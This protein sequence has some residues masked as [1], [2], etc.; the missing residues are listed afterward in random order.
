MR[1]EAAVSR[2]GRPYP[3]IEVV[4]L[5]EPREG[6][7]LVRIIACGVCHTD[8]SVHEERGPWP[9]IL[10]HEGVGVVE[11]TGPGVAGFAEGDRVLLTAA[12]HCGEC[13]SCRRGAYPY[14]VHADAL[15]FRGLRPDG[16]TGA[17]QDGAP[18]HAHFFG[19]SSFARYALAQARS[20]VRLPGDLPPELLAPLGCGVGTGAGSV[21]F[22]LDLRV[23]QSIAV[24]GTG[25]VGLSAIMAARL[26]GAARIVAVDV[27][28][29]RLALARELGATDTVDTRTADPVAAVRDAT[30]GGADVTFNTTRSPKVYD[31]MLAALAP[32]GT[33]GFVAPAHDPWAPDLTAMMV[34]GQSVRGII[35][36]GVAA[37]VVV[38][39]LIDLHRQGRFPFDRL[40]REYPFE[41]I[42][43]AFADS[44]AGT[45]VKPV[46]R[47]A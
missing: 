34:G 5:E 4:E 33:A 26:A 28:P 11:R 17:S 19:Q 47:M 13:R 42:G 8:L 9:I 44:E 15:N 6:E 37:D 16:T 27:V 20:A 45:T 31:Q 2:A 36:G 12:P 32:Q 46:L 35:Q 25:S 38:P 22:A 41:R 14:C 21:L 39:M 23:G 10:G 30:G 7:L 29:S 1:I 3:E 18:I 24:F 43:D 40:V